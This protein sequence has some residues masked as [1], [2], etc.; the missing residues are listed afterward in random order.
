[1]AK[2]SVT[3]SMSVVGDVSPYSYQVAPKTWNS[4][5][6][7]EPR[8][9][10]KFGDAAEPQVCRFTSGQGKASAMK[11]FVYFTHA[12]RQEWI[13]LTDATYAALKADKTAIITLTPVV[14]AAE[15][16]KE[17]PKTE[18]PAGDKKAKEKAK[19]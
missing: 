4:F 11:Y 2:I 6:E 8:K 3:S 14:V 9:Q 10:L 16:A 12:G 19:A 17:E 13:Q 5:G 7:S 15:P 18:A 1:M